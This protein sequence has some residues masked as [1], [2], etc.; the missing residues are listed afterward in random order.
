M[1]VVGVAEPRARTRGLGFHCGEGCPAA[2]A[3]LWETPEGAGGEGRPLLS[4]TG[5]KIERRL[6]LKKL[7]G[8]GSTKQYK[9][10]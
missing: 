3:E 5:M 6:D 7:S 2:R 4:L 8:E 1:L 9:I 10:V